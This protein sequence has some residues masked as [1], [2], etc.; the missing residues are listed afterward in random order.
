[1]SSPW[2]ENPYT[3]DIDEE[4]LKQYPTANRFRSK[5][6]PYVKLGIL[7]GR[8]IAAVCYNYTAGISEN[9]KWM[10]SVASLF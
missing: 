2:S 3:F 10:L 6:S 5:I 9:Q 4:R 8:S 1:M 7:Q